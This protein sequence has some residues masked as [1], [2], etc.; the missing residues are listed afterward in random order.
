MLQQLACAA[1]TKLA[2]MRAEAAMAGLPE[3]LRLDIGYGS[4]QAAVPGG[5]G[6]IHALDP[7]LLR[8][9]RDPGPAQPAAVTPAPKRTPAGIR[10]LAVA[11]VCF[12]RHGLAAL[13]GGGASGMRLR[14]ALPRPH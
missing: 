8:H 10:K 4:E 11:R 14:W 3:R 12:Q 5:T 6:M 1:R 9:L 13:G 2:A 7:A